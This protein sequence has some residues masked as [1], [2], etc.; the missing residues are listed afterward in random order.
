MPPLKDVA[1]TLRKTTEYLAREVVRSSESPPSWTPF[2][3]AIAR[4]AAAIQGISTLLANNLRWRGDWAWQEFLA[5]QRTQSVL[6]DER[7]GELLRRVDAATQSA[8]IACV[9]LK[10]AALRALGLY[11]PGERPMGDVDLLVCRDD[12]AG[13]AVVMRDLG[14]AEVFT[15]RRHVSYEPTDKLPTHC[16]GEHVDNA[17]GIEV[18][19]LVAEPLPVRMVDITSLLRSADQRPG[20]NPY[21]SSAALLLH[22]HL[23]LRRRRRHYR[24]SVVSSPFPHDS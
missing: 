11:G 12:L 6:R 8:R 23:L 10:G 21:P 15:T 22:L 4:C 17:L 2:E 3:W 5:E 13:I 19:P 14:Y 16:F 18:H 24:R 7:I 9:G 20:L 1:A